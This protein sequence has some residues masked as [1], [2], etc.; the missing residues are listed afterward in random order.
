MKVFRMLW[1]VWLTA[2]ICMWMNDVAASWMMTSLTTS[3]TWVALVQTASNIPV[4][5]LGL[6]SGA[7]ADIL[8]RKRYFVATQIWVA[9]NAALL[10]LLSFL[11]VLNA[12]LLLFLT[13]INGIGLAMRWPVF[14]AIVP[15]LVT[16]D[17]LPHLALNGIVTNTGLIYSAL[18][19]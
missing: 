7:L 9:A 4:F 11:N 12:P 19:L 5:L 2:N 10:C 14:S 17:H 15:D 1:T 8:N 16:K 18:A 13:F 3:P 6:P